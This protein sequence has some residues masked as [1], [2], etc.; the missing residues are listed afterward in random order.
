MEMLF[1]LHIFPSPQNAAHAR[2]ILRL[3]SSSHRP[4]S[5]INPP[6]WTNLVTCSST[7]VP[8]RTCSSSCCFSIAIVFVFSAFIHT[9]IHTYINTYMHTYIHAYTHTH[10]YIYAHIH[11][12]IHVHTFVISRLPSSLWV[13]HWKRY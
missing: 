6:R 5:A 10:A 1:S 12:Y 2:H 9:Y 11:A 7:P 13:S 3:T 8:N 4:S